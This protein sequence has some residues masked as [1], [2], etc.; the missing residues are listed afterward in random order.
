MKLIQVKV[1]KQGKP[2]HDKIRTISGIV[3]SFFSFDEKF[4]YPMQRVSL[5]EKWRLPA[6]IR[7]QK[8]ASE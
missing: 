3:N 8:I 2:T 7:E 6:R 4:L 1:Q 5:Q